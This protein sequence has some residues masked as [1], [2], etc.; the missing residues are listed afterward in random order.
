MRHKKECWRHKERS[1]TM[2]RFLAILF[3]VYSTYSLWSAQVYGQ[4]TYGLFGIV[5]IVTAV[6]LWIKKPW[7][8]YL[9]YVLGTLF[10]GTWMFAVWQVYEQGW[11]YEGALQTAISLVPGLLMVFVVLGSCFAIWK[12]F[13]RER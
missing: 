9:A 10:I 6:G 7:S 2:I 13:R 3:G 8:Q 5:G 12:A 1:E 4:W 11:P